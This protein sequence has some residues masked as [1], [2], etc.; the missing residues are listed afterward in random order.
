[1]P[2]QP[3][4][5][6]VYVQEEPSGVRTITGV[7]TSTAVFIGRAKQGPLNEPLLCLSYPDFERTFSSV[8]ADSD[9][10]RAVRLFFLNGGTK[11]Y[12][13]RIA[14]GAGAAEVTLKNEAGTEEVLNVKAK[15]A[16][17]I[18]NLIR[19]AVSYDGLQPES[20]FNLEVFRWKKNSQGQWVKKDMEIWKSL[21][22]DPNH[23]RYA[24]H[25]INQQ[26]KVIYLTNIVTSTPVDGYSRSGRP[27]AGLSDLLS[28]IDNDYSRFRISVDG[29]AFEEVDL[30]G[31]TDLNDIQSRI[32]TLL[33]T[34]SVTVSLK[35]GP[36]STQYLQIS[37][38]GG[39][40]CIEPAADKDLS[41]TLMLGTAQGG[42]EVSRFAY[43]R[44]APNGIVF[45]MDK[46]NDFAAL[47]QNDFDTITIN[48]VEI[49]L[50]KLNTTGTPADP[51]YADGYLPSPNVT[52]NNDGIREKWNIIAEAINDKR[53][54]QSDFKWTA[55]VWGSRLALIPGAD[56]DNE[57]GTLETSGGGGTDLKSYF[58]FNVR[59]YSLGT[60]G[61]GSYQANGANGKDGDAPKQKEYK[62]AFE[63]L[64]KEVDLFNLLILPRDEDHK[65]EERNSLWGPAS[66]FCQEERAF[67]LMDAPETWDAVQKATNPSDGVNSLRPG[68]VKDHSAV[69]H[70]RLIIR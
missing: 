45:Q 51:M 19:L 25:Y 9:L 3:T 41:R 39:D 48:G 30:Y 52:G 66:I 67:L 29:G 27:V 33:P 64:R 2:V 15:S 56:G 49:N 65:L 32:N 26:S 6:G 47:A 16:G 34:G 21:N 38:T 35:T 50:N 44:P 7:S 42:I 5:P 55:K 23:P 61:T 70:P 1:M 53:I 14:N 24:V 68:L 11:C 18:G 13:M 43:Q 37:S 8:Y 20:T 54:D 40:V 69:F 59:Y 28:L 36:S 46:L 10:A 4:Y 60:T 31:V 58:L 62:D 57:I 12:V 17:I 63:I 22:M